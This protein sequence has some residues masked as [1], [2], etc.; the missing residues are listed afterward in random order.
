MS[1]LTGEDAAA[2]EK[3]ATLLDEGRTESVWEQARLLDHA[4]LVNLVAASPAA[5]HTIVRAIRRTAA[6]LLSVL[7]AEEALPGDL[8]GPTRLKDVFAS[9]RAKL[10][11][12]IDTEPLVAAVTWMSAAEIQAFL[13]DDESGVLDVYCPGCDLRGAPLRTCGDCKGATSSLNIYHDD[14]TRLCHLC[15]EQ[16]ASVVLTVLWDRLMGR[17]CYRCGHAIV[18]HGTGLADAVRWVCT[19]STG[20]CTECHREGVILCPEPSEYLLDLR[21][22]RSRHAELDLPAAEGALAKRRCTV[23]HSLAERTGA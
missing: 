23:C 18:H 16:P 9:Q 5:T 2:I 8:E 3:L 4:L 13:H 6:R 19:G 20:V 22:G 14:G 21:S 15:L 17:Y 1:W 12:P 10:V 11:H 7:L